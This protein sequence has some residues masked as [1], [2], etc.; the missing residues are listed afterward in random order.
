LSKF[1]MKPILVGAKHTLNSWYI[2]FSNNAG[3]AQLTL[4]LSGHFGQDVALVGVLVLIA[5]AGLLEA[6]GGATMC[7]SFCCHGKNSAFVVINT[8]HRV[9]AGH[10]QNYCI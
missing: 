9:I 4:T 10:T 2:D 1:S 7:F 6:L 5:S 3:A 8:R